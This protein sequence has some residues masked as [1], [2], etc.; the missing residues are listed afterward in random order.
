MATRKQNFFTTLTLIGGMTAASLVMIP[1]MGAESVG[2]IAGAVFQDT[3]RDGV[4]QSDEVGL[5]DVLLYVFD[6]TGSEYLGNTRTDAAGSFS[7]G[8]VGDGDRLV[9]IAPTSW[10]DHRADWTPSNAPSIQPSWP[11][12][13]TGG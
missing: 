5:P 7:H 2:T 1:A 11:V 8:V 6:A 4:Q 13:V 9:T 3:N 10:R 12:T